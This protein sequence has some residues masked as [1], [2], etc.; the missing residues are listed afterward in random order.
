MYPRAGYI[1]SLKT[2]SKGYYF[3][4]TLGFR[5]PNGA[6]TNHWVRSPK[7]YQNCLRWSRKFTACADGRGFRLL[8]RIGD[9]E[10]KVYQGLITVRRLVGYIKSVFSVVVCIYT[11]IFWNVS[12]RQRV[13]SLSIHRRVSYVNF[14][15]LTKMSVIK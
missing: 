11:T 3:E 2:T 5:T 12:P 10:D 7:Q 9:V 15:A 4:L 6:P 13:K 1:F 14:P 8:L